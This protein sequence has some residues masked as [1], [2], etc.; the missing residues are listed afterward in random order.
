MRFGVSSLLWAG[1]S[2]SASQFGRCRIP[3]KKVMDQV[4]TSSL[5]SQALV[6][7]G[8]FDRVIKVGLPDEKGRKAVLKVHT[9]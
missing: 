8:R 3:R 1:V 9:R 2:V 5:K 4:M 6:R 7:P